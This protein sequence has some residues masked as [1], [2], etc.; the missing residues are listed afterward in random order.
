MIHLLKAF[1]LTGGEW[2][3]YILILCSIV[4]IAVIIEKGILFA[5][6][7]KELQN[8]RKLFEQMMAEEK[9]EKN[10]EELNHF[11]GLSAAV[12]RTGFSTISKGAD[13]AEA[14]MVSF[15]NREKQR[16]ES[17]M[18]IL[19]TLG[20]NAIY[21]GLFGT[22]LGVIK[23][24]HDL[25]QESGAGPEVVMQGLSE[26]LIATAVGLLVSIPCVIAYNIFQKRLKDL[27]SETESMTTLLI[28]NLKSK[29]IKY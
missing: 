7:K 11:S 19:G 26:A 22:V 4:G 20:N 1:A 5:R 24:F 18:I 3:I 9:L 15:T 25:A 2:V 21:I 28:A 14:T 16:L 6:E 10:F 12:L 8:V 27:L 29:C 17:H 13:S 23:A